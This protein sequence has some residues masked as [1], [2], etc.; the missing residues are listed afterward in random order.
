MKKSNWL[1]ND[2]RIKCTFT[3]RKTEATARRVKSVLRSYSR[4][5]LGLRTPSAQKGLMVLLSDVIGKNPSLNN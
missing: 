1:K 4:D 5:T 2:E 3:T